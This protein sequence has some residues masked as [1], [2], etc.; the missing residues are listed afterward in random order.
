MSA[1]DQDRL[2]DQ[3]LKGDSRLSRAYKETAAVEP[4]PQ[5]DAAILAAARRAAGSRPRS[6]FSPFGQSW[7]VPL[8]AAA[9]LVLSV[10]LVMFMAR[11]EMVAPPPESARLPMEAEPRLGAMSADQS[12]PSKAA[13]APTPEAVPRERQVRVAETPKVS[14]ELARA[15][16][17]SASAARVPSAERKKEATMTTAAITKTGAHA[18]VTEVKTSGTA[19]AYQFSVTVRSPD[20]GCDQ[21]ADWWEVVSEDGRLLYR[22]V[23]LHSHV[24]E[25][26]FTRAGG[27]VP[28]SSDQT[29]WV[30]AHMH[31]SGYGGVALRGSVQTGF[32]P[33]LM[34]SG[35]ATELAKQPPLPNGCAF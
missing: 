31:P 20:R 1:K 7:R 33:A 24:D 9:V 11:E 16:A 10:G 15:A 27:P 21:F 26:P 35:F 3:Y 22:R 6:R 4:P 23:L 29:V 28:I 2:F 17:P 14:E 8:A 32:S 25:Q 30:R 18:D 34:A 12:V 13:P 19:G 5:L